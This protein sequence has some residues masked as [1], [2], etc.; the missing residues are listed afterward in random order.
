MASS[1]RKQLEDAARRSGILSTSLPTLHALAHLE[2]RDGGDVEITVSAIKARRPNLWPR[3]DP[4]PVSQIDKFR[5]R[6]G[7]YRPPKPKGR[8][9]QLPSK[10]QSR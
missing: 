6:F 2:M 8:N 9:E 4:Q 1:K 10:K 7:D 3:P 5:Q